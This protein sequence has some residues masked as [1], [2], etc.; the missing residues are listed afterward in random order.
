MEIKRNCP[1]WDKK[2]IDIDKDCPVCG[3][4]GTEVINLQE[5]SECPYCGGLLLDDGRCAMCGESS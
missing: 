4:S 1:L 5:D 3:G 2:G